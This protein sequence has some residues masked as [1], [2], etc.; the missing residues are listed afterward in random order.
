MKKAS[1]VFLGILCFCVCRVCAK[2][3]PLMRD[4]MGMCVHTVQFKPDLYRPV[5]RLVR[6]YHGLNWDL[7][8]ERTDFWP[9]FPFAHNRVD[10][11]TMYAGWNKAGFEIDASIQL[12]GIEADKWINLPRDAETYGFA[13]ARFFGPSGRGLVTSAEI[14]NEP[15]HYDDAAYRKVFTHMA[16]GM[17]LGDPRLKIV[18]CAMTPGQ[19]HQYAKSLECVKGLEQLYD[20]I[21]F[22]S[23]AQVQGWP[24]WQRSYPEDPS[25]PYLKEARNIIDWRDQN[26]SGKEI[27]ITEFGW[28]ASTKPAPK[29]GTFKDW[30]GSTEREQARY[31]VRS[32]L[33]FSAM[34]L[35]RAYMFWFN[36]TDQP[37]VHGS[38]GL[39][40]DY[41]PKLSFYAMSY[42]YRTL[43]DY[44]FDGIVTRQTGDLYVYRYTH[45]TDLAKLIFVAWSPTG[46]ERTVDRT[47][48][49][50]PVE[51]IEK[52]PLSDKE[53]ETIPVIRK[54]NGEVSVP[55]TESPIFLFCRSR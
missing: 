1:V 28:D 34:D 18:T 48:A 47:I 40:R 31:M 49:V 30:V 19:S 54:P 37:Q 13:F 52:M 17:R 2:D 53:P 55:I 43:G 45:K 8:S 35:D 24:T 29:E 50:G 7:G 38:S 44:R 9:T 15:G 14:G 46:N 32:F 10:W 33:V 26:A 39:T 23:Y 36:D 5:C 27:W 51:R 42:L 3:R 41:T 25:I 21:N 6:D 20:V 22:H 11:E 16:Q 12:G 4:F